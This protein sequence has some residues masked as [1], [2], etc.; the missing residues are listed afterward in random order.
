M[1]VLEIM[2]LSETSQSEDK[3]HDFTY[4][5]NLMNKIETFRKQIANCQTEGGLKAW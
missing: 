4:L 2:V 1:D 3:Y 5:W